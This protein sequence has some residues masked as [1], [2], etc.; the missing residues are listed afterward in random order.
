MSIIAAPAPEPICLDALTASVRLWLMRIIAAFGELF[1]H[2]RIAATAR[3]RVRF[4][5]EYGERVVEAILFSR[6]FGRIT[7]PPRP[8]TTERPRSCPHGFR[9]MHTRGGPLRRFARGA[10][11]RGGSLRQRALRLLRVLAESERIVARLVKRIVRG[12]VQSRL[13]AAAPPAFM[14]ASD[15]PGVTLNCADT[16]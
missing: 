8:R 12:L 6:A 11:V 13:T 1:A 2:G 3:L 5:V 14:L 9:R 10:F 7:L 4:L 16:S 15:A